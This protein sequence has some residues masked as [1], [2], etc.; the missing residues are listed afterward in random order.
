MDSLCQWNFFVR[1][2]T[3]MLGWTLGTWGTFCGPR[4]KSRIDCPLSR[5]TYPGTRISDSR[6][7]YN[8]QILHMNLFTLPLL[9][10]KKS[11]LKY[12]CGHKRA[13]ESLR[14]AAKLVAMR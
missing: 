2:L 13:Y 10:Q 5:R 14:A 11:R 7:T 12:E 1:N 4:K 9:C 8:Y 6:S 3:N